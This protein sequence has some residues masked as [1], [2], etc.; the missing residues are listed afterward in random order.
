MVYMLYLQQAPTFTIVR[1]AG[2]DGALVV[3][4]L[5]EQDD[6]RMG[7]DAANG[8][9]V[10]FAIFTLY[11]CTFFKPSFLVCCAE[12]VYKVIGLMLYVGQLEFKSV[13]FQYW[14]KTFE[15]CMIVLISESNI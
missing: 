14:R 15:V 11:T 9:F 4:K 6:Y 1:N 3:G 2:F 13:S 12:F 5:L 7:Y 10:C 8:R